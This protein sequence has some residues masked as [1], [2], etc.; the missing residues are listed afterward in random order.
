MELTIL[1]PEITYL[2]VFQQLIYLIFAH[3]RYLPLLLMLSET[4]LKPV[5][6]AQNR[7]V[8]GAISL[9]GKDLMDLTGNNIAH[10]MKMPGQSP[11]HTISQSQALASPMATR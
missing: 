6:I 9:L 8:I 3:F 10:Q 11:S 1:L 5:I 7:M 4:D 2:V